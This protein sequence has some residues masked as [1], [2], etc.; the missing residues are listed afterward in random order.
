VH[1][2]RFDTYPDLD[3]NPIFHLDADPDP[4]PT[5]SYTQVSQSEFFVDFFSQECQFT[6]FYF[7]RRFQRCHNFQYFGQHIED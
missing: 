4:D 1:Q 3:P 6:L 7:Y 5:S 2:H